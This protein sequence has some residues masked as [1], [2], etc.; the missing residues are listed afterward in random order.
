MC[1][2]PYDEAAAVA[3]EDYEKELERYRKTEAYKSFESE[4]L[5]IYRFYRFGFFSE[6]KSDVRHGLLDSNEIKKQQ[7]SVK[8]TGGSTSLKFQSKKQ[9]KLGFEVFSDTFKEFNRR[10]EDEI[11]KLRKNANKL[12][13]EIEDIE[14]KIEEIQKKKVK[15]V[16]EDQESQIIEKR[17][18]DTLD[19][20]QNTIL[21]GMT[22]R[23]LEQFGLKKDSTV[24]EII[25]ALTEARKNPTLSQHLK[26]QIEGLRFN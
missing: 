12:E 5:A 20:Y 11:R 13:E 17:C 3:R 6:L 23:T 24:K 19:R 26:K 21:N 8:K 14:E 10:R 18:K 22:E 15:F 16:A 9:F 1:F 25:S 4:F 7:K 2:Q